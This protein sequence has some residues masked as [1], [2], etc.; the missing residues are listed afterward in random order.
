MAGD[1]TSREE[2]VESLV[3]RMSLAEK[4][5]QLYGVW[6]GIDGADGEMAPHQHEFAKLHTAWDDLIRDGLGQ[7]T[8][9]FGTTP[10]GVRQGAATLAKTQRSIM[11]AGRWGSPPWCTRRP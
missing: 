7:I 6:V 8:R 5:A 11:A 9:P 4:V 3:A 1:R 10:V 2:I